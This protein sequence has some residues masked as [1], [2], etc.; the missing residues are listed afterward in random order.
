MSGDRLKAVN[1]LPR[2]PCRLCGVAHQ[3]RNGFCDVHQALA[4]GWRSRQVGKTTT[5]RGYGYAWRELV[6]QIKARDKFC[7]VPCFKLGLITPVDA[8]DHIVPKALGGDD[9]PSNLQSICKQCH[10]VKTQS[11][12]LLVL[13]AMRGDGG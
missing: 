7:C 13:N 2:S 1:N 12:S 11:E 8:V 6:K 5:Q 3:N 9:S 4:I 10:R